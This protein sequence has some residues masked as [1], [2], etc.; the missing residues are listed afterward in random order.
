MILVSLNNNLFT[1]L[2][3]NYILSCDDIMIVANEEY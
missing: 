3:V 2:F 1:S